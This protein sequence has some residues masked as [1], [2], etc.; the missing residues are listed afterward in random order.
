[1]VFPVNLEFIEV[2]EPT[3]ENA[4][5]IQEL[6][7]QDVKAGGFPN[8][9]ELADPS[10]SDKVA[11]Q[12]QKLRDHPERY[13][14]YARNGQLVAYIKHGEW[15]AG[16]ELPFA[17]GLRVALLKARSALHLNPSTGQWGV[18]GLVTSDDL[19]DDE[20]EVA[21]V[22]LLQRS[23]RDS[24]S[25]KFRTVNVVIHENDPLLEIAAL[26]RFVPVGKPAEAAGAPGLMQQRYRRRASS[27]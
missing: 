3:Y 16:D 6:T 5:A 13:S 22:K 19:T 25:G 24:Q 14:G 2:I 21:L 7:L 11:A 17:S 18:F 20:R 1:M 12:Q 23:F 26:Y 10:S 8:P 15:L 4:K 9:R 27:W